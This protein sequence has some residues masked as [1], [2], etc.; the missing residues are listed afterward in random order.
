MV[1][2]TPYFNNWTIIKSTTFKIL[3]ILIT[4]WTPFFEELIKLNH[5]IM[6]LIS[7]KPKKISRIYSMC[8]RSYS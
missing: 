4:K 7:F 3:R 5:Q 2:P 1:I 6:I 8:P